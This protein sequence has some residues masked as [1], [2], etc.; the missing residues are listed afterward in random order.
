ME[1]ARGRSTTSIQQTTQGTQRNKLETASHARASYNFE[2]DEQLLYSFNRSRCLL[3]YSR[4]FR[5]SSRRLSLETSRTLSSDTD[6]LQFATPR[7]HHDGYRP[8]PNVSAKSRAFSRK[9]SA[10]RFMFSCWLIP[11][12]AFW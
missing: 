1:S 9:N 5:N 10:A 7:C 8:T 6:A 11:G 2:S 12:R 4:K 3:F